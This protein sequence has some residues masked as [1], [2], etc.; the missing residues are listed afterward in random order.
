MNH[1]MVNITDVIG[2]LDSIR[3]EVSAVN[4][5]NKNSDQLAIIDKIKRSVYK[6]QIRK[7]LTVIDGGKE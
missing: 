2:I 4:S 5:Y 3:D 1:D 7:R 6:L